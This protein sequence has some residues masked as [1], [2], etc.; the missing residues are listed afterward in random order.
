M[1]G[2]L[3]QSIKLQHHSSYPYGVAVGKNGNF[4]V[5]DMITESVSVISPSG[6][7][8][9]QFGSHGNSITNF[10]NPV[11][12]T[13]DDCDNVFVTDS[14][15]HC[16]KVFNQQGRFLYRIGTYGSG[17]GQ[18]RY[19]KSAVIDIYGHVFIADSG[20]NRIV[21]YTRTGR[22]L[23]V[24]LSQ[25]QGIVHPTA[26]AASASG[27]LAVS[28]TDNDEVRI[29]EVSHLSRSMLLTVS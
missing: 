12:V 16:V 9:L 25:I 20:N 2:E 18:L 17:S 3:Q 10:D 24:V 14:C 22:Y 11:S 4:I 28:M 8:L 13:V 7:T 23:G 21:A 5:T 19:P 26:L 15:H 6:E 27:L 29:Y 1:T